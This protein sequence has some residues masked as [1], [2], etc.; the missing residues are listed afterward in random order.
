MVPQW[1]LHSALLTV[2]MNVLL[3][4]LVT[5]GATVTTRQATTVS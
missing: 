1:T 4:M 2:G 3:V 5:T